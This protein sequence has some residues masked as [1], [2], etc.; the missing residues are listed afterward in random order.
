MKL[1]KSRKNYKCHG[2]KKTIKKGENYSKKSMS[3]GSPHKPD[4]VKRD[5]KGIVYFE[6]QG[7]RIPLQYCEQCSL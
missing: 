1:I 7:I 5:E 4:E 3:I 2:C 6:M